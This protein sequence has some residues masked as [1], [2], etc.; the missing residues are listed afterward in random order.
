MKKEY[1]IP[2]VELM[3]YNTALMSF[4]MAGSGTHG[5]APAREPDLDLF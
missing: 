5:Q 2:T 3:H 4:P 1:K